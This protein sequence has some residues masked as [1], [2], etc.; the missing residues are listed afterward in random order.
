MNIEEAKKEIDSL[1]KQINQHNHN[2]YVES[3]PSISDYDFDQKLERLIQLE[4]QF[5]L[6]A[7]ENSPSKRVGGDITKNFTVV[8]HR[9]PMLSLSNTYSKSEIEDWLV[10]LQK[11]TDDPI[12]FVCELKYDGVA[13]SL[14][15]ENQKLSKAITRGD[16]TK[17]EDITNNVRTIKTIPLTLNQSAP[18]S[19]EIRGEIFL[20][21]KQFEA[22][23]K[24]RKEAEEPL[25]A[26]PRNTASG[27]LKMQDSSVVAKRGL[28]SFLYSVYMYRNTITN[29]Y[30]QILNAEEW[31]FK[32]PP[33]KERYIEKS[34]SVEEIMNFINHWDTHR[35]DLP[36]EIDG[37]VLKVNNVHQQNEIGATAKSPRW[38]IA[39]KFKA[40]RVET[41][42]QSVSYQVGR[43]GAI[44]P[45]ANLEPV[46]LG[47]TTVKRASLHNADQIEKNDLH[48]GDSVYLEKGGEI[49]PKIVGVNQDQ[50]KSSFSKVL[51]LENC[52]ECSSSLIRKEGEAQHFCL[53]ESNCPPQVKGKMEHFIGRKAM[54]IDG[55]GEETIE[56]LYEKKLIK[57]IADLYSLKYDELIVLDRMADKSV[58]NVLKGIQD[59]LAVP[60]E[61]VLFGLG[62]RYVGETIAKKITQEFETMEAIMQADIERLIGV[63]EIGE[64]IAHSLFE[65]CR[66]EKNIQLIHR[67]QEIGLQ[68]KTNKK[69]LDSEALK[70]KTIVVSG[71][72]EQYS[73][74]EIKSLIENNGGKVSSSISKKTDLLV[75]GNNMGPSKRKKANDL[76]ISILNE[77]DFIDL[78]S[79]K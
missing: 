10:R 48:L 72:F 58:K 39:Y 61:K 3:N 74:N 22:L 32:V 46:S 24:Q 63:D 34:T 4:K 17:G 44:T 25:F 38:A 68:F 30:Q 60:F 67:L 50:R 77:S 12:E 7:D 69:Q 37:I 62:I 59:S 26:N 16:G 47:G 5:P 75:A 49:I 29:H 65:Y 43:T 36:F 13:I 23:N 52:P 35:Y 42:L 55:V 78:I 6:L 11:L 18:D 66:E 8:K 70:G 45:V 76:E 54:N 71:V 9:F 33:I 2:Y 31:G 20:P 27:T 73:R 28:D 64:R 79:K 19:F 1:V 40:E 57:D 14:W 56:L 51:F 41:I 53:N 15:Y 21:L